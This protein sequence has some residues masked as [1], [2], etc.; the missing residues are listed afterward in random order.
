MGG[1]DVPAELAHRVK[2]GLSVQLRAPGS[3]ELIA[4]GAVNFIAPS[5]DRNSQTLLVKASFE[6]S[7]GDLR[8]QQRVSATLSFGANTLLSVPVGAV[9]LQ[10]GKTFVFT[11][12]TPA[13]AEKALARA[14]NPKP[15]RGQLVALQ[16]PVTLGLPQNG[17]YPVFQ[18]LEPS[19]KVV[20][21]SLAQ[22]RSG[23]V[24][25]TGSKT[26]S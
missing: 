3:P 16:V 9:L 6:N 19:S 5:L 17:R 8:D 1:L 21:G 18:G 23:M 4:E 13:Q 15:K 12:V 24:I 20:L 11:A 7:Q 10:A 14:L 26:K 25:N 22:L 2:P